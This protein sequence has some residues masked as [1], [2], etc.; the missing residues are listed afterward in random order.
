MAFGREG[1]LRIAR[2]GSTGPLPLVPASLRG[3]ARLTTPTSAEVLYPAEWRRL[4]ERD[5]AIRSVRDQNLDVLREQVSAALKNDD[6]LVG[7][8]CAT[9]GEVSRWRSP[10]RFA[11][12]GGKC[13]P[14]HPL[15]QV[16]DEWRKRDR[17]L[18]DY[19]AHESDQVFARR[20][21]AYR[22]VAAWLCGGASAV[23]LHDL[24]LAALK[25][26]PDVDREDSPQGRRGRSQAQQ[27]APGELRAAI[28]AAAQA[29][30]ISVVLAREDPA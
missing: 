16:L 27:A 9:A 11:V 26:V 6:E 28:R 13:P 18:W 1:W 21:D 2:I 3:V 14:D 29:R 20:R 19:E 23:V 22:C 4:L 30:G 10:R 25:V 15:A 5:A 7:A 8:L 24:D 12:L 17:H